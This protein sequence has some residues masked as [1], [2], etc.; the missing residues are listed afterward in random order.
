MFFTNKQKTIT[1]KSS[2]SG[3]KILSYHPLQGM[4]G[5]AETHINFFD[6][7]TLFS[8]FWKKNS[9]LKVDFVFSSFV[10]QT[11]VIFHY[12]SGD[13]ENKLAIFQQHALRYFGSNPLVSSIVF[14]NSIVEV[15]MVF[16]NV[17]LQAYKNFQSV[18][19]CQPWDIWLLWPWADYVSFSNQHIREWQGFF[20]S[21]FH[22]DHVRGTKPKHQ[23]RL[24]SRAANGCPFRQGWQCHGLSVWLTSWGSLEKGSHGFSLRHDQLRRQIDLDWKSDLCQKLLC[25]FCQFHQLK[26][27]KKCSY[28]VLKFENW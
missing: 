24:P 3:D 14:K 10:D 6:C 26:E 4:N 18:S 22:Q 21:T 9:D 12:H 23:S 25:S 8:D 28:F 5:F 15:Y 27:Y 17:W 13:D 7:A 20:Q 1:Y 19:H 11:K 16:E 2:G